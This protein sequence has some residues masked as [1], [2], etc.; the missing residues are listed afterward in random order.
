MNLG[1]K[2]P[3]VPTNAIVTDAK[4]LESVPLRPGAF[5]AVHVG[6][7]A[8][9]V[10]GSDIVTSYALSNGGRTVYIPVTKRADAS[11]L[12]VVNAVKGNL[13][14][15]QAALPDD[16]KVSYEFDQSGAVT[17]AIT[18][19][20]L[21]GALGALLTGIMVLVFLRDRRAALIVVINIPLALL[22]ASLALWLTGATINLMSLGGLAL[23]VGILVDS[24]TVTMENTHA[25]LDMGKPLAR[26]VADCG[27]EVAAP[28]LIA[29]LCVLC[30]FVP[31]LFMQGA[32]RALFL[33]LT[34][35]VGF[36]M[37]ASW[38]LDRT[39]VPIL[40]VWWLRSGAPGEQAGA[41]QR[42]G[43]TYQILRDR[44]ASVSS[45]LVVAVY[46]G[47][48]GL[49]A[50]LGAGLLGTEI[51]PEGAAEQ[52]QLRMRAPA[53]TRLEVTEGLTK[54]ALAM[55]SQDAGAGEV[56]SSLALVG[57]H[58]SAYPIS[59]IHQW[60]SG[61]HE[62]VIQFQ[63]AHRPAGGMASFRDRLRHDLAQAL[64]HVQFSFE[65]ASIVSR[66]MSFGAPTPVEVTVMG[67]SL[68]DNR[69]FAEK[70]RT[71]LLQIGP[72]RDV[73]FAQALDYPAVKVTLDRDMAGLSGVTSDSLARSLT[74]YTSSSRFIQPIYWAANTGVAFQ[75]QVQGTQPKSPTIEDLRNVPVSAAGGAPCCCAMSPA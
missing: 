2:Y 65:P 50:I 33:P 10:D 55:I 74:P 47:I 71:A 75:V 48:A 25:H 28:L 12:S 46:L 27:R 23:A 63:L 45:G 17:H 35:A 24:S 40:S 66:V 58:A 31:T 5:P 15:F 34:L 62:A 64:P 49:M 38:L 26:A 30:V 4:E 1:D 70:I 67:K 29:M 57:A 44:L 59:Y 7:V 60:S 9:V 73:Q 22:A 43:K 21:E 8:K 20:S 36:A 52:V 14:K 3:I 39:L 61:P 68:D 41:M 37:I 42:I 13:A 54:R 72:L 56:S 51:F 18:S 16:V 32:A 11:T 19:L 69:A 6:D 53:G